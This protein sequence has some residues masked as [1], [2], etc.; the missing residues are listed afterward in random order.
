MYPEMVKAISGSPSITYIPAHSTTPIT[1]DFSPPFQ[2]IS[3]ISKL[4]ELIGED[5]PENFNSYGKLLLFA[6]IC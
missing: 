6:V 5:F 2:R 1:I 4:K 3:F